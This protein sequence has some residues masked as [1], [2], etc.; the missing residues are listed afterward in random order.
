MSAGTVR[1]VPAAAGHILGAQLSF[2]PDT[3]YCC[4]NLHISCYQPAQFV[5]AE[6]FVIVRGLGDVISQSFGAT[7][8]TFSSRDSI[9]DLRSA[10]VNARRHHVTVLG[11]AGDQG[12]TDPLADTS[13]CYPMRVNSWPSA[14]PLVTSLGGT[15]LHVDEQGNRQAPDNVWNDGFA[16]TGGGLSAIFERP[17]FQNGVR[18]TSPKATT[19]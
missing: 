11:S 12:A 4:V 14:D 2:P 17:Q 16:A 15:Q 10:F 7:E 8:Q 19:A 18:W 5:R 1:P 13:C 9:L 6:N 3:N